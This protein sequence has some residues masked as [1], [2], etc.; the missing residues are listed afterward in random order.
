[1]RTAR[2]LQTV[3]AVAAAARSA[4]AAAEPAG[5]MYEP[6]QE[7]MSVA[8][9]HILEERNDW[10]YYNLPF[11]DWL[12]EKTGLHAW[13][14]LD[15]PFVGMH[16]IDLSGIPAG[17]QYTQDSCWLA[18]HLCSFDCHRCVGP[19]DIRHCDR[20]VQTFDDGPT[21]HSQM[22]IDH[23]STT[24]QR[25][26]FFV[27]GVQ[28]AMY[29]NILRD[30]HARGHLLASHTWGHKYLPSLS[31]EQVAAQLMWSMWIM[32]A[33]IGV[34][35]TFY[36]PPFGGTDNRIRAIAQRLGLVAVVWNLDSNDWRLNDYSRSEWEIYQQIH[37]WKNSGVTGILLEH[38]STHQTAHAG[39][40]ISKILGPHQFTVA[41]CNG[42]N[43]PWYQSMPSNWPANMRG[44]G[45]HF[46]IGKAAHGAG[47][48]AA[49]TEFEAAAA[50]VLDG[51]LSADDAAFEHEVADE[52]AADDE[53]EPPEQHELPKPG[54]TQS[55][56]AK[57]GA[58]RERPHKA[59][60]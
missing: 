13:P 31:N 45:H 24:G 48:P 15:A 22:L 59:H 11:P 36:R 8:P 9:R 34:I 57:P 44:H 55:G 1:M 2:L 27:L 46:T 16:D 5:R 10:F 12:R 43:L 35:P 38:D 54:P 53:A 20:L 58:G 56:A 51:E 17:P 29:P 3:V 37:E 25:S 21:Q 32:N 30:M 41:E 33:T 49:P 23:M 19:H 26:T 28:M 60:N 14:G 40:E 47:S 4:M 42:L 18:E 39:I 7:G 52:S 50:A 6:L